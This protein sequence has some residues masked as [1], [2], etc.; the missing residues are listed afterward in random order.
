[1]SEWVLGWKDTHVSVQVAKNDMI[2]VIQFRGLEPF[3]G[4]LGQHELTAVSINRIE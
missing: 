3:K 4:I 2:D 1:M